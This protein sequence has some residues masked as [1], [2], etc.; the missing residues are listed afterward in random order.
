MSQARS[1]LDDRYLLIGKVTKPH[2]LRGDVKM[3]CFSGQPENIRDYER[4]TLVDLRGKPVGSIEIA[5]TRVK[6][7]TAIVKFANIDNRNQAEALEGF[8]VFLLKEDLPESGPG[9]YYW[10]QYTGMRIVEQTGTIVGVVR[11]IFNSGAQ[12]ILVVETGTDEV[13]I[14]VTREIVVEEQAD[15]IIVDLPPGLLDINCD[16]GQE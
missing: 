9:E 10:H 8:E 1:D 15:Q 4:L 12:D 14:P 6:G 7:K 3:Y 5:K 16:D 13:M 2:G 11:K